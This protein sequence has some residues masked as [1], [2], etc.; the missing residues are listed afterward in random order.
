MSDAEVRLAGE[1]VLLLPERALFW[2]RAATL[3]AADFHWGKAPRVRGNRF[4]TPS[5]YS[6]DRAHRTS[7]A[8]EYRRLFGSGETTR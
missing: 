7:C 6:I 1:T 8:F 4:I 3:V 5:P 2:P